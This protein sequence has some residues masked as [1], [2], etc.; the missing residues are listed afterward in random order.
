M[1]NQILLLWFF[2]Q[3]ILFS[4]CTKEEYVIL[5]HRTVIVYMIADNNLEYFSV[6]DLNEMETGWYETS[7]TSNTVFRFRYV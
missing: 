7:K 3:T 6:Q 2:L 4:N 1:N 5:P